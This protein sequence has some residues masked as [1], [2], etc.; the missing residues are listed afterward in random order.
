M[1]WHIVDFA[2]YLLVELMLHLESSCTMMVWVLCLL[3][4][5]VVLE[6]VEI[7]LAHLSLDSFELLVEAFHLHLCIDLLDHRFAYQVVS[8]Q[9]LLLPSHIHHNHHHHNT[10][11]ILHLDNHQHLDYHHHNQLEFDLFVVVFLD[12]LAIFLIALEFL[13]DSKIPTLKGQV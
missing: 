13:L 3:M 8:F 2:V 4:E 9:P 7:P 1:L 11:H 10:L 5:L 6:V 12:I